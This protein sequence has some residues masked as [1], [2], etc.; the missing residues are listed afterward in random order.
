[1]PHM[2]NILVPIDIH[3][4][5]VPIVQWAALF[6][7][8]TSS[9]L[10]LLHV[11]ESLEF[12]KDRPGLRGGGLPSLDMTLDPWRQSYHHDTQAML[13]TLAQQQCGGLSVSPL[14]LEGR[15]PMT[16]LGAIETT[17]S[18]LVIM[19]THG[20]PWYQHHRRQQPRTRTETR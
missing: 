8:T 14:F 17:F 19:G 3:E 15:A 2:S 6:A 1:M 18:D 9:H 5:A 4:N 20:R 11:N 16:I 13:D 10:T 7:R 12:M